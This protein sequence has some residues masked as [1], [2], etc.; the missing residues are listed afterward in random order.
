MTSPEE[1]REGKEEIGE[2][3]GEGREKVERKEKKKKKEK[4]LECLARVLK[5]DYI[6]F[7]IFQNE[8]SFFT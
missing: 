8:I 2:R 1:E 3:D 5:P 6:L 7:S 4:I